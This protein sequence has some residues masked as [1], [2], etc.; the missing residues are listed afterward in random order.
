MQHYKGREGS[1]SLLNHAFRILAN[2]FL[3]D[4][5]WR[6]YLKKNVNQNSTYNFTSY[7]LWEN[8]LFF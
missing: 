4:T 2:I 3:K 8:A 1:K 6:K 5:F 7:T